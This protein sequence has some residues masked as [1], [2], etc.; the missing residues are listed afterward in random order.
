MMYDILLRCY[1]YKSAFQI[2]LGRILN[3]QFS[4]SNCLL[5]FAYSG[6][7]VLTARF[8]VNL[9]C[10]VLHPFPF[11]FQR[12]YYFLFYMHV[13]CT[14]VCSLFSNKTQQ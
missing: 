12:Q 2:I 5:F 6:P 10:R 4:Y 13:S 14:R 7:L 3:N 9:L 8:S 11:F 1:L